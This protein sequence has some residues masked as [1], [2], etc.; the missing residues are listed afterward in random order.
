MAIFTSSLPCPKKSGGYAS[1]TRTRPRSYNILFAATADT[2]RV[3]AAD[4]KHLGADLGFFAVLHTWGQAL[5][6][7]PH[8]HC[9]IP[10]GG[11]SPDGQRWIACRPGFF[12]PVRVLSRYF[13][14]RFLELLED[15]FDGVGS[16]AQVSAQA[17]QGLRERRD[18][19]ALSRSPAK[20][21]MGRLRQGSLC[22]TRTGHLDYRWSVHP[23]AWRS[24]TI[25]ILDI[26]DGK[27]TFSWKDYRD[28]NT[29]KTMTLDADEFI[30]R[31]LLHVLPLE[32][33]AYPVLRLYGEPT[34]SREARSSV[35]SFWTWSRKRQARPDL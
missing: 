25:N 32:A 26:D 5:T 27:V 15:A 33:A 35:A 8:L 14:H 4:P 22:R 13:R 19:P 16:S 17:L 12:L 7:H 29:Q 31:F 11:P 34:S 10:G 23:I 9:V 3:I 30:R 18:F 28:D 21:G 20:E 1:L 2:L 24:P 6:H